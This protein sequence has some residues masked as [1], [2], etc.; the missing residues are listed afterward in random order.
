[1]RRPITPALVAIGAAAMLSVSFVQRLPCT[2]SYQPTPGASEL[3]W[4]N[5]RPFVYYCYSDV[6][7]LYGDDHLDH[8]G[9]FPYKSSWVANAGT[10]LS[11]VH[12]VEYPVLTGLLMW[13]GARVT[14]GYAGLARDGLLP[15]RIP[16][17]V[18]FYVVAFGLA[19]AWVLTVWAVAK[20]AGGDLRPALLVAVSPLV[21]AQLFTNFDAPAVALATGGI[22]AWSR[23]RPFLAGILLGLGGAAKLYPLL[24]LIPL[25][26]LCL[27]AGRIR[28]GARVVAG[29]ILSW[30]IVNAPI[31]LLF[32]SGWSYFYRFSA[33]RGTGL[34]SLYNLV[35]YFTGWAGFDPNLPPNHSP[36]L[37]NAVT[38]A[39]FAAA[40]L[41][42]CFVALNAPVRPRL[43]QL[44]LL[45]VFA[46]LLTSK[47]YSPQYSLWLVPLAALAVPRWRLLIPWMTIDALVWV[48]TMLYQRQAI[49]LGY[50]LGAVIVRDVAVAVV[51]AVAIRD[52]YR[53]ERDA[54]RRDTDEDPCAGPLAGLPDRVTWR[55]R[56]AALA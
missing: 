22:F 30:V 52:I 5:G 4:S 36:G 54:V 20:L 45:V 8:P 1:M 17:V 14:D 21:L 7:A 6:I 11:Q 37:L 13:A 31:A 32:P 43:P 10:P 41:G 50:F 12:Y 34:E 55:R 56:R 28:V 25:V 2:Q 24:L 40:C 44:G 27:R 3:N 33:M 38:L 51:C 26:V 53:P 39:L 48:P 19:L 46:F 23:R 16:V 42:I 35:S 9:D 47:I 29:A 49:G 15:A 18:Y